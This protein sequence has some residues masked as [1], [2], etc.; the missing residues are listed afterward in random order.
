MI[1]WCWCSL[2]SHDK[3]AFLYT[4]QCLWNHRW[5][6]GI[7]KLYKNCRAL[8]FTVLS[9]AYAI[10]C[11]CFAKGAQSTLHKQEKKE[12]TKINH[13][14]PYFL[15][16][17]NSP[18]QFCPLS[19]Y[20]GW[21]SHT[22]DPMVLVQFAF[23]WQECFPLHSSMSMKLQIKKKWDFKIMQKLRCISHNCV[24]EYRPWLF[25]T[26]CW[27][28]RTRD[29]HTLWKKLVYAKRCLTYFEKN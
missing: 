21:Q 14:W 24:K 18:V 26:F 8:A 28:A 9:K 12:L 15:A 27:I 22:C 16:I 2:H 11:S 7:S 10:N 13:P 6:N 25:S 1:H 5:K 4:R 19:V 17:P 23:S 29:C 3:S 20:P